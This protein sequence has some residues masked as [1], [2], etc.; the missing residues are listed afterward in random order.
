MKF[1]DRLKFGGTAGQKM[2]VAYCETN[3]SINVG[4]LPHVKTSHP[5]PWLPV[6]HICNI[7]A[8]VGIG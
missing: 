8:V 2:S 5:N 4:D 3:D 1:F 6:H 7:M